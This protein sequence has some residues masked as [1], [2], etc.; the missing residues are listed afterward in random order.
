MSS[1][2]KKW[3]P[4]TGLKRSPPCLPNKSGQPVPVYRVRVARAMSASYIKIAGSYVETGSNHHFVLFNNGKEGK[5]RERRIRMV[6]MQEAARRASVG[7]SV[8]N[9]APSPEWE[10]E[11]HYELDLCVN[12]MV[13]C[14]DMSIFEDQKKFDPRHKETPYFR[15]QK[16]SLSGEKKI[17]MTLRHHSISGT[18][19]KWGLWRISSLEK[20]AFTKIQIGNLG[21]MSDDS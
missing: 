20:I 14:Q 8:I 6:T 5:E 3:D 11:W 17:D 13:R 12:D 4:R 7:E 9:R 19:T 2:D 1:L 15:A 18:D 21:L 10:G 16:M